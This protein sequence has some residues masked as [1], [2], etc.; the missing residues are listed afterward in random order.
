[1]QLSLLNNKNYNFF[2]YYNFISLKGLAYVPFY[3]LR[4]ECYIIFTYTELM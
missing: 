3:R 1:M 2:N 4:S